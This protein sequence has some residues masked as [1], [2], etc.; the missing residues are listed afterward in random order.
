MTNKPTILVTAA[1]GQSGGQTARQLLE[2]GYPVRAF[3]HR[4]DERADALAS[5][6]AEV[7]VGDFHD[8]NSLR[9]ALKGVKR[10][11]FC[12][13]WVD[14]LLEATTNFAIVAKEAGLE[15]TVNMSHYQVREGHVSPATRQHWLGEKVLDWAGVGATHIRPGL[16][17][18]N[19]LWF[20]A[21]TV[22]AEGKIYLPFGESRHAPVT[23]EDVATVIVAILTDPELRH[24]GKA[25]RLTG[26]TEMTVADIADTIG[27]VVNKPVEY[28]E[29]PT[30]AWLE[31]LAKAPNMNTY[32]L[33][34]LEQ[35]PVFLRNGTLSGV[36]DGVE[37]VAG[38]SPKSLETFVRENITAFTG[39]EKEYVQNQAH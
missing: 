6:G 11:Y 26:S 8:L 10:A 28:I 7:A 27:R 34:H 16:F 33:G 25:Y 23:A 15:V 21:P 29:I 35:I 22:A 37:R 4:R 5:L 13:P 14:R 38:R 19:L 20:A 32:F 3:V 17:A 36:S 24:V 30:E 18:D 12:L 1:A 9:N 2:R 39:K 31:Q